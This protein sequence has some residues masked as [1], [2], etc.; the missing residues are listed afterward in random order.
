MAVLID[1]NVVIALLEHTDLHHTWAE[2]TFA[3]FMASSP[4]LIISD[5]V[6]CEASV[7]MNS[8]EDMNTAVTSLGLERLSPNETALFKAG[9]AFH[10]YKKAKK[11]TKDGVL[12]DFLIGAMADALNI[13]IMTAD[14]KHYVNYFDRLN[15]I[16]PPKKAD[17]E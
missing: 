13:P 17:A 7:A 14:P 15:V 1:T 4:P 3:E 11:G 2:A 8:I 12:P 10:V 5:I 6:Y 9:K 16:Q